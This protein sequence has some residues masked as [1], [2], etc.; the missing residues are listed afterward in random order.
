MQ[1]YFIFLC[2][3]LLCRNASSQEGGRNDGE[4]DYEPDVFVR[5][6]DTGFNGRVLKNQFLNP[7][8]LLMKLMPFWWNLILEWYAQINTIE[9]DEVELPDSVWES[10][11]K[12]ARDQPYLMMMPEDY[13]GNCLAL[14]IKKVKL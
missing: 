14:I 9:V 5:S 7:K 10:E 6:F 8:Q 12:A 13:K 11:A 3:S 4:P 1:R 2:L